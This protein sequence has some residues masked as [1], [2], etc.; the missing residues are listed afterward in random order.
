MMRNIKRA[1]SARPG[2]NL[3]FS[4]YAGIEDLPLYIRTLYGD[5]YRLKDKQFLTS[6]N[7]FP[8]SI[9]EKAANNCTLTSLTRLLLFFRETH[10]PLVPANAQAVYRAARDVFSKY[11]YHPVKV[12]SLR[13]RIRYGPWNIANMSRD[14]LK[15]FG[16][17][18]P[19]VKN[20]YIMKRRYIIDEIRKGK[21]VMLNIAFG[22]YSNHTVSVVGYDL[23]E[24]E[25]SMDRFFVAVYD[26]WS[27]RLRYI[28]WSVFALTPASVTV[29]SPN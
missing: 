21:P 17:M 24:K 10:F 23:Y 7:D 5:N 2:Q 20:H 28:D 4:G 8:Q 22:D 9:F 27:R 29:F 1:P 18:E 19:I 11:G 3:S 13:N 6:V 25:G 26:G 16:Y 12:H 15:V 14:V